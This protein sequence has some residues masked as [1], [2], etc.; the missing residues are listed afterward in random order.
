MIVYILEEKLIKYLVNFVIE[1]FKSVHVAD[2]VRELDE[3]YFLFICAKI[4]L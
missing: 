4:R 3:R 2:V 1:H